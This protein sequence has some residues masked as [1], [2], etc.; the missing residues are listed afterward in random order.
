MW[1]K[2]AIQLASIG[3]ALFDSWLATCII[4]KCNLMKWIFLFLVKPQLASNIM[5]CSYM[6]IGTY[7]HLHVEIVIETIVVLIQY[8]HHLYQIMSCHLCVYLDKRHYSNS[9]LDDWTLSLLIYQLD[10]L[11]TD[12]TGQLATYIAIY[13]KCGG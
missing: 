10:F 4:L 8:H 13:I 11:N 2:L 3:I 9:H 12:K 5:I 1:N 6:C 7:L